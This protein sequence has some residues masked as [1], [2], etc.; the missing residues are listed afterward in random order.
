L[1]SITL[2]G[3]A[4]RQDL[5]GYQ[6]ETFGTFHLGTGLEL[7]ADTT[8]FYS[9]PVQFILGAYYGLDKVLNPNGVFPFIGLG[10]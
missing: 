7:K 4:Y 1:D 8:M 3:V 9:L 6:R 5:N 2:D 10:I